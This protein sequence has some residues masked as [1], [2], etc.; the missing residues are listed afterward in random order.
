MAL[1]TRISAEEFDNL[2]EERSAEDEPFIIHRTY[3]RPQTLDLT[4]DPN[5]RPAAASI[6][7]GVRATDEVIWRSEGRDGRFR[8][9]VLPDI[10]D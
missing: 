5:D 9:G 8:R 3:A 7:G 2:P 4:I 10:P 1:K 6:W